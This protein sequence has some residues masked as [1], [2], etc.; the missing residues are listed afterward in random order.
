MMTTARLLLVLLLAAPLAADPIGDVRSALNRFAAR[1]TV[2]A[3]YELQQSVKN[4]GKFGNDSFAGKIAVDLDANANG[5]QIIVGR[6]LLEQIA[7]EQEARD[8]NPKLTTPIASA[9]REINAV[10]A[11]DALDF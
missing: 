3:T 6:P 2:H 4:E 9:L 1:E 11:S 7:R 5:Y 8:R 10:E